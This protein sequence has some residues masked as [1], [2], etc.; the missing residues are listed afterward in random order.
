MRVVIAAVAR[1]LISDEIG[2][3]VRFIRRMQLHLSNDQ[4]VVVAMK[5]IDLERVDTAVD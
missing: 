2:L 3:F 5:L 4:P 1:H